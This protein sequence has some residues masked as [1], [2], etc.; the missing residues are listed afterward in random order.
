MGLF[1]L[2]G[3]GIDSYY[4]KWFKL[5]K[6]VH[7]VNGLVFAGA[8]GYTTYIDVLTY[9]RL[10]GE[11]WSEVESVEALELAREFWKEYVDAYV[12][13]T[14]EDVVEDNG[15]EEGIEGTIQKILGLQESVEGEE[16]LGLAEEELSSWAQEE[17]DAYL[18]KL[19]ESDGESDIDIVSI[20][21][22]ILDRKTAF[23]TAWEAV[24]KM[25]IEDSGTNS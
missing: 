20:F 1:E 8:I 25:L 18:K 2:A 14:P 23:E 6:V 17:L 9:Y 4:S 12:A 22:S 5:N 19:E 13:L 21:L 10:Y 24:H 11:A 7:V 15:I 16:N 3:R